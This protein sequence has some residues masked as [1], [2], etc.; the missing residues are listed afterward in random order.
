[1]VAVVDNEPA[2]IQA[3]AEADQTH[4]ILFLHA[5]TI[6]ESQRVVTPRTVRGSTY[7]LAE[8]V[9]EL[10]SEEELRRRVQ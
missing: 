6:F 10:V 8:L 1:V 3:M 4:E 5:D 2:I 7:D 9:S